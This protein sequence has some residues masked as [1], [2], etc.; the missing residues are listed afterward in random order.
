MTSQT[1]RAHTHDALRHLRWIW[2]IWRER[3]ALIGLLFFLTLLSSLVAVSY[4]Y[5]TKLL[6]DMLQQ[7][8]ESQ[9][10]LTQVQKETWRIAGLFIVVGLTGLMASLF[11]GIRGA[12]NVI[13]EH[14]IRMK[15]FNIVLQKDY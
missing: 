14:L 9:P 6:I 7:L 8:I 12:V 13:F 4:P 5:L 1:G 15:Y 10:S 11:P 3:K 2:H